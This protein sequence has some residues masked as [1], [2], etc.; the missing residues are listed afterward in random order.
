MLVKQELL[1]LLL[2]AVDASR[3]SR[4]AASFSSLRLRSARLR[5]RSLRLGLHDK[6]RL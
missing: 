1:T 4:T 6:P 2:A 5:R 3:G